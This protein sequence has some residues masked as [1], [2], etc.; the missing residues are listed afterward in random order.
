MPVLLD[1][2][3][4]AKWLDPLS[5]NRLGFPEVTK[6]GDLA[7]ITVSVEVGNVKHQDVNLILGRTSQGKE[8]GDRGE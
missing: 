5:L 3:G 4:V 2:G 1:E 8:G 7:G 6:E